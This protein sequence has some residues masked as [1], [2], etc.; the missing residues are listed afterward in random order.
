MRTLERARGLKDVQCVQKYMS[1]R[2]HWHPFLGQP[3]CYA[4][5]KCKNPSRSL[6]KSSVPVNLNL[7]SKFGRALCT[8]DLWTLGREARFLAVEEVFTS[9][10]APVTHA[11]EDAAL[12]VE[13]DGCV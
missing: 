5:A 11:S 1:P 3:R 12:V 7:L 13:V 10:T 8:F 6:F 2:M 9:D 4:I